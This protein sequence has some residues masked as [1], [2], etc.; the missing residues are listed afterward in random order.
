MPAL[1]P[2]LCIPMPSCLLVCPSWLGTFAIRVS[3]FY[4]T[5]Y[6]LSVQRFLKFLERVWM[7]CNFLRNLQVMAVDQLYPSKYTWMM[8]NWR[9]KVNFKRLTF[10]IQ[11]IREILWGRECLFFA[12]DIRRCLV[13]MGCTHVSLGD[14][15]F[16]HHHIILS[17]K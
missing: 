15:M 10:L 11:D 13:Q 12:K 7:Q 9:H 5:V 6:L 8:N 4:F 3:V 17:V 2:T 14:H 16:W 1:E